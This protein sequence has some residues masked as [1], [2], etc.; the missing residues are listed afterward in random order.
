[1]MAR[2]REAL[3]L[4]VDD[5]PSVG[6]VLGTLIEQDLPHVETRYVKSAEAA[7][8]AI[9]DAAVDVVITDLR[10]PGID[11]MELL[12]RIK[13]EWRDLPVVMM[14]A[15][16]TVKAAIE[17]NRRGADDFVLKPFDRDEI[18]FVVGKALAKARHAEVAPSTA[19]GPF[20]GAGA[21]M[22]E[23]ARRI[24]KAA[25][26]NE[27]VLLLGENGTGKELAARAIHERSRRSGGPF[28]ALNC[29]AFPEGLIE[30]ELFGY[31]KGA[32]NGANS[33][34]PGQ[35]EL[36]DGGTLFLD[37][38]G[39]LPHAVQ[40]K[41][42]RTIN[43]PA[44][45]W[46][47]TRLGA[48]RPIEVDVRLV[49]ATNRNLPAMAE[50]GEYR[51]D[52]FERIHGIPILLPPLRE[53]SEEIAP[54]ARHFCAQAGGGKVALD[55]DAIAVL[56]RQ[57][58]TGNVRQLE[59]FVRRL[60]VLSDRAR[61]AAADVESELA[62]SSLAPATTGTPA[63][64]L[65]ALPPDE[66]KARIIAALQ[67]TGGNITRAAETLEIARRTLHKKLDAYGLR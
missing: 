67:A 10:M 23:V 25:A 51:K 55:E 56:E 53:R 47:L 63:A 58:W 60:V 17:A 44:Q 6:E 61:I 28:I 42:L 52:F 48:T 20:V 11:G 49:C 37:E 35:I 43:K 12:A 32:F 39:E 21:A 9:A 38:I 2:M 31:K 18:R 4:V 14:T 22:H 1:M 40:V 41:L 15:Y 5:D 16:A 62:Q 33:D 3:V 66:E 64:A 26:S 29:A 45:R 30:S 19:P 46:T 8:A 27:P 7:I 50:S 59:N 65:R 57:P 54:L 36:A 24:D 34:K 13:R